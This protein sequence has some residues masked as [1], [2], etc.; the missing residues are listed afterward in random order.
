M[1]SGTVNKNKILILADSHGRRC[2][3]IRD[4]LATESELIT[5]PHETYVDAVKGITDI[6]GGEAKFIT[7]TTSEVLQSH[8]ERDSPVPE[9]TT[10][11]TKLDNKTCTD[12]ILGT[13]VPPPELQHR[14]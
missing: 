1:E 11:I 12:D 14:A 9:F 13:Q 10:T 8:E 6:P 3:H 2:E 7:S 4:R 5:L